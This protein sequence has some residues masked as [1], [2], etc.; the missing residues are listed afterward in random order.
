MSSRSPSSSLTD[1]ADF[2]D[3]EHGS[4]LELFTA[5]VQQLVA[6]R[7]LTRSQ[8]VDHVPQFLREVVA[9]VRAGSAPTQQLFVE[10]ATAREHGKQRLELGYD[11]DAVVREYGL[12]RDCILE[13]L[14]AT[15]ATPSLRALRVMSDCVSAATAAAVDEYLAHRQD[16]AVAER[17]HLLD[18]FAQAPGFVCFLRGRDGVFELANPAYYQLIGHRDVI[19]MPLRQALPEL[20]G[21]GYF[22]LLEQVFDTGAPFVGRGL[23]VKLQRVRGAPLVEA[24][25]DLVYQP[26]RDMLGTVTGILVQGHDV[27]ELRRQQVQREHVETA[28]RGSEERYRTLFESIDDGYCLIEVI[29]DAAGRPFDYRFLETNAAFEG[30]TGLAGAVGKTVLELVPDQDQH[31]FDF[32]G[33]VVQSGEPARINMEASAM[34]RWYEVFANRVGAPEQCQVG[35]VFKDISERKRAEAERERLLERESALR[36]SAEAASRLRDDFL[37]TVSH[38]LRTPLAAILG[39]VQMLRTETLSPEKRERAL[40]TVERNARA[41]AQLVEDLLDVSRILAG[42]LRLEVEHV[43]V[44]ALI[45]AALETVLPAANAKEIQIEATLASSSAVMG[46]PHR[47]HQVVWN[48][49][50]N[51]VKFTPRGGRVQVLVRCADACVEIIVSDTGQGIDPKL[52]D[53]IFDRFRQ[54]DGSTTRSHGGLGLGLS[55]VRQLV[56]M[57]GGSVA[58]VSAGKGHGSTFTV[59]LPL[60][61]ARRRDPA[62]APEASLTGRVLVRPPELVGLHVLV[63]DDEIDARDMVQMLLEQCGAVVRAAGSAAEAFQMFREQRP[64][65]LVSDIGMPDED[66]YALIARLRA[67]TPVDGRNV[68]AVALTAYARTQDRTRAL[69]AGFTNHVAKPVEPAELLAVVASLAR[70]RT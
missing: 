54:A 64:D 21:Q 3:A 25:V 53:H 59:R 18:M 46:D 32:Y 13:R 50:S 60:A 16:D 19:G 38:E 65:V 14:E 41:Q 10:S 34:N 47:L 2:L 7:P 42:K 56:D 23:E 8:L 36:Q 39:W 31:W 61:I 49:L 52:Q 57:H 40:E 30:H 51:S 17:R 68:P 24:F 5:R 29:F 28:L 35:V 69:L 27:T 48:L 43:E 44:D 63:V 62:P 67:L 58:V 11:L 4:I 12:L 37:A 20:A 6:P 70:A 22:E 1:L 15:Q 9:A 26:I 45:E 55:I 66:G 33:A